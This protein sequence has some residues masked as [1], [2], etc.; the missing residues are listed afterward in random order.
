VQSRWLS[1][2]LRRF[3]LKEWKLYE[4]TYPL[5]RVFSDAD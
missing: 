4:E 2:N 3:L 5:D 1:A